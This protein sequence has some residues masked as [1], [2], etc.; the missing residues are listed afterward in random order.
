ML[1]LV[2]LHY[3]R[4]MRDPLLTYFDEHGVTPDQPG[5]SVVEGWVATEDFIAYL[6]VK[7]DSSAHLEMAV[8]SLEKFGR[9]THRHVTSIE[10]LSQ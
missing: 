1:Y 8:R 9:V 3:S 7:A 10:D 2:E 4:D 6:I 5:V